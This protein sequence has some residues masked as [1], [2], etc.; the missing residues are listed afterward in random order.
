MLPK[1]KNINFDDVPIAREGVIHLQF[2]KEFIKAYASL[3]C[4]KPYIK[5]EYCVLSNDDIIKVKPN[6]L[7]DVPFG[8]EAA[9]EHSESD[10]IFLMASDF[11]D[12]LDL[13]S[14][15]DFV[16]YNNKKYHQK[17]T[18]SSACDYGLLTNYLSKYTI[19]SNKLKLYYLKTMPALICKS[20]NSEE[21]FLNKHYLK[22]KDGIEKAL[23][24]T[25]NQCL[26]IIFKSD[27]YSNT[28]KDLIFTPTPV[29]N[30][31]KYSFTDACN[32][33]YLCTCN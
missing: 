32:A 21:V 26:L 14:E 2:L 1:D 30:T 3:K 15:R 23:S 6:V 22:T 31:F 7:F 20:T 9:Y 27:I 18:K 16:I 8:Y 10:T 24:T 17:Y 29:P 28:F 11:D 19:S 25:G 4:V 13:Y 5:K 12:A 33:T